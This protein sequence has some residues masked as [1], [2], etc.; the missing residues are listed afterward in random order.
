MSAR[1]HASLPSLPRAAG[2]LLLLLVAA[3]LAGCASF[4]PPRPYTTEAEALSA[5]GE[6]T[7]RWSNDDGTTTLYAYDPDDPLL[8]AWGRVFPGLLTGADEMPAEIAEHL[9]YPSDLFMLQAE[10]YKTYHMLDPKVFYNKEDLWSIPLEDRSV[11]VH[12][13]FCEIPLHSITQ[14]TFGLF[15]QVFE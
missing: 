13:E 12:Q 11:S 6:P 14:E 2:W 15:S 10:V 9:R 4:A 3:M 7:R 1:T 8:A 5:R